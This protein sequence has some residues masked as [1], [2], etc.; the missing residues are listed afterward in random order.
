MRTGVTAQL[1]GSG[2]A[3]TAPTVARTPSASGREQ[4]EL[5]LLPRAV[6]SHTAPTHQRP[7]ARS[8]ASTAI[9]EDG[10][11]A[12]ASASGVVLSDAV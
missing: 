3:P 12:Q 6:A 1:Q 9:S 4:S 11:T 5:V 7:Y 8:S 10:S 2:A